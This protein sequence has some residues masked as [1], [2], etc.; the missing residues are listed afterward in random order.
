MLWLVLNLVSPSTPRELLAEYYEELSTY[1]REYYPFEIRQN[2]FGYLYQ[3]N[4]FEDENLIDLV[5]AGQ[6]HNTRFRD[7][8]RKLL[9]ELLKNQDYIEKYS[10]IRLILSEKDEAFLSSR[11]KA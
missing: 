1:T 7:Y 9:G 8:S 6:H 3:L 5:K 10:R 2:A 4:A 11:L